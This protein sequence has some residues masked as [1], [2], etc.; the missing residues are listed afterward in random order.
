VLVLALP[1]AAMAAQ[2]AVGLGT[3]TSYAVLAGST[4]V[5]TGPS[6]ISGDV[7]LSPG[8]AVTGFPPGKI[9][10]GTIHAADAAALQAKS[11]LVTAFDDAAGRGPAVDQT[12]KNLGQQRLLPGVYRASGGLALTGTLT[13]DAQGDPAAVFVLQAGST[14]VTASSSTVSLVGG[15]QACNV[16][17]KVGS[18]ATLG[19]DSVLVGSVLALSDISLQTRAAVEGRVLARNGA[20]TLDSNTITRPSCATTVPSTP[21][22]TTPAATATPVPV[23]ATVSPSRPASSTSAGPGTGTKPGKGTTP[24]TSTKPDQATKPVRSSKP[25][26]SGTTPVPTTPTSTADGGAGATTVTSTGTGTPVP[27]GHPETG[28]TPTPAGPAGPLLGLG[29]LG[30]AVLAVRRSPWRA[31]GGAHR[32][33]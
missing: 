30:G 31:R 13:L 27:S 5:N 14:L 17:W 19:T 22:A 6:S 9:T 8:S 10:G 4:V 20:V 29:C 16:F 7:G 26:Q 21:T 28:R 32:T 24:D 3:A 18:S 23:G 11:D 1:G 2:P 25:D 12:N 33:S 15:A